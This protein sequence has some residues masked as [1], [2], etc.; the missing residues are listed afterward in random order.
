MPLPKYYYLSGL[1]A[2]AKK[3]MPQLHNGN[4]PHTFIFKSITL[5]KGVPDNVH[6][7]FFINLKIQDGY[8]KDEMG[9]LLIFDFFLINLSKIVLK[10]A[11]VQHTCQLSFYILILYDVL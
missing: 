3:Y 6:P 11:I 10:T 9:A 7:Q 4:I 1:L 8:K 5:I 2:L